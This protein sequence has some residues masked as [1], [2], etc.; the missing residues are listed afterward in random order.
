MTSLDAKWGV[1]NVLTSKMSTSLG[2]VKSMLKAQS[3]LGSCLEDFME[4]VCWSDNENSV[5]RN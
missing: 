3:F 2:C 5:R 1:C 4:V